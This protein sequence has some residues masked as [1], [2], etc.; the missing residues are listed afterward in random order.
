MMEQIILPAI[1][2][3]LGMILFSF[4]KGIYDWINQK[5]KIR[6]HRKRVAREKEERE[7]EERAKKVHEMDL[8]DRREF[9]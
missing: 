1:S 8:P 2:F 5:R 7:T 4:S 3:T 9:F 6:K